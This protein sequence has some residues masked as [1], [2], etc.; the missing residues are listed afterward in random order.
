MHE[1][2]KGRQLGNLAQRLVTAALFIPLLLYLMFLAPPWGIP[3]LVGVAVV[4]AAHELMAMAIPY[5]RPL[6]IYGVVATLALSGTVL[7]VRTPESLL[8]ALIAVVMGGL[9]SGLVAPLPLERASS[10]MGWLIA[11]PIYVGVLLT[12]VA[13]LHEL[14]YG[15]SWILL[16]MMLAWFGDT[17]ATSRADSSASASST[18]PSRRRRP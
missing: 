17:G 16:T 15:G 11:G 13:L 8:A 6:R 7:L 4:V 14:P 5:S 3:I 9:L 1:P 2:T 10:R 12:T 18:R